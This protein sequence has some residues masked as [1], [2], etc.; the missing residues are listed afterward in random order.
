MPCVLWLLCLAKQKV[1]FVFCSTKDLQKFKDIPGKVSVLHVTL[2]LEN[3]GHNSKTIPFHVCQK[4]AWSCKKE[5]WPKMLYRSFFHQSLEFHWFG[6]VGMKDE[7][8]I[9]GFCGRKIME[10]STCRSVE[11]GVFFMATLDMMYVLAHLFFCLCYT[12]LLMWFYACKS[13]L[14]K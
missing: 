11:A 6:F 7:Y 5:N 12:Y 10:I 3:E 4:L 13:T 1:S 9:T 8:I 14:Y 2:L